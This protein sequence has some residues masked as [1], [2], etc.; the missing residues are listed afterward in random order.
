MILLLGAVYL[1]GTV[2]QLLH[3]QIQGLQVRRKILYSHL[4]RALR[5]HSPE[6]G[7]KP[8]EDL[9]GVDFGKRSEHLVEVEHVVSQKDLHLLSRV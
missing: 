5:C 8:V 7:I 9:G 3:L 1:L 6:A 2:A 4:H